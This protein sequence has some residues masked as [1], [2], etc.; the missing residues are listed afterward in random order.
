MTR[1][2]RVLKTQPGGGSAGLGISPSSRIRGAILAVDARDRR[3]QRLGVR[4]VGAVEHR[5]GLADLH[6]PAQVHDRDPVGQVADDAEVVGDEQVAR[7]CCGSGA[8]TSTFRMAA[9]TD[10]SR[11][12][13]GSS[14]TTMRRVAGERPGDRHALLE[15]ARQ[16]ARL[17]VEVALGERRSAASRSTRSLTALPLSPVSLV[18]ERAR[19][20]AHGPAPVERRVRVLEDHLDRALVRGRSLGALALRAPWSSSS[21]RAAGVRALDAEDGLGQGRLARS[22]L[23]DQPERLAVEQARGRP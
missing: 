7:S 12:L 21:M 16:L 22:R 6:D 18:T 10:T 5:L 4:V 23:A 19:M 2:Q 9:W 14:A 8:P 20:R 17:E 11:A 3:E 15:P 13:V 1:W